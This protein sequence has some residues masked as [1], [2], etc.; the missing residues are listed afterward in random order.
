[1]KGHLQKYENTPQCMD[2]KYKNI[3]Q[4]FTLTL[5]RSLFACCPL[6][7]E[8]VDPFALKQM[9][10]IQYVNENVRHYASLFKWQFFAQLIH[11]KKIAIVPH[12]LR[13]HLRLYFSVVFDLQTKF[14][15]FIFGQLITY[16]VLWFSS[17]VWLRHQNR[18]KQLAD[19]GFSVNWLYK[20]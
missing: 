4:F 11:K 12:D 2:E 20:W 19:N 18:N 6:S 16:E 3:L 9:K 17:M 14:L 15:Y 7:L 5:S 10:T 8:N 13:Q 1:M